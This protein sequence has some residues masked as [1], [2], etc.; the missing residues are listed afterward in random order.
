MSP[1]SVVA[2]AAALIASVLLGDAGPRISESQYLEPLEDE[3]VLVALRQSLSEAEARAMAVKTF[4]NPELGASRE[5]TGDIEQLDITVSW[6]P[7]HPGRR[8]LA[9]TAA[10]AGVAAA[11]AQLQT[12]YAAL[13]HERREAY[14]RWSTSTATVTSLARWSAELEKLAERERLR[15]AGGEASGLDAR[16]LALAASETRGRL[17]RAES[18]RLEAFGVARALRADLAFE[19][20]PDLPP[21]PEAHPPS[22]ENPWLVA[23]RAELAAAEAERELAAKVVEM[24]TFSGGW[25]RQEVAGQTAEGTTVGLTWA[26]PLFD[27]GQAANAAAQARATAKAARLELAEREARAKGEA[28]LAAYLGLRSASVA[29][30]LAAAEGAG[31]GEAAMAAFQAG[32]ATLTDLLDA[33]R[34]A[35][36]A[37]VAA[38][39]LYSETLA[40]HRRLEQAAG[41]PVPPYSHEKGH[42]HDE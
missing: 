25:Q 28:T 23:L 3:P 24:P 30:Q 18:E 36:E 2:V 4:A 38:I 31:I 9:V 39:E 10:E 32:E 37:E 5:A 8:H 17:A 34:S 6:Q 26:I 42:G 33:L 11:R 40:T 12:Q 19:A 16:R 41:A 22:A 14:A 29:A 1:F 21:L 7:P 13:R 35:S 20:I 15:A 27:R